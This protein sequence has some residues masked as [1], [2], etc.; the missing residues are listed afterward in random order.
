[1]TR[2]ARTIPAA[3]AGLALAAAAT[4]AGAAGYP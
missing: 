2:N 1:M 4:L 3:L